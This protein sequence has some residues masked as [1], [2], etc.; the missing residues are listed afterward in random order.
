MDQIR[1][2]KRG[3]RCSAGRTSRTWSTGFKT[4]NGLRSSVMGCVTSRGGKE[5]L[6]A[7]STL[8][9][10]DCVALDTM[11]KGTLP[12]CVAQGSAPEFDESA[13]ERTIR[14]SVSWEGRILLL[15]AKATPRCKRYGASFLG[16]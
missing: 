6:S 4:H 2:M 13:A 11:P 10:Y 5:P 15:G 9:T 1:W 7:L 3:R 16:A 8:D 14:Y 12:C